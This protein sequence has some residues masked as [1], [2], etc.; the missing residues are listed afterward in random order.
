MLHRH[1]HRSI[2]W[3]E[4]LRF[5]QVCQVTTEA[6]NGTVDGGVH[7][8]NPSTQEAEAEES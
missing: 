6:N 1:G 4:F 3:R 2:Q 7:A 8:Y 5:S